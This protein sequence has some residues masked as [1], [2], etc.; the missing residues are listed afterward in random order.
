MSI[1][2]WPNE[3][4]FNVMCLAEEAIE[5]EKPPSPKRGRSRQGGSH[6]DDGPAELVELMGVREVAR[7]SR[8]EHRQNHAGK[9]SYP[10]RYYLFE[11]VRAA[12]L[13]PYP[14]TI[15]RV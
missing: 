13:T 2:A 15:Q 8:S 11:K 7:Q 3:I 12:S 6:H 4:S 5:Q 9:G 14:L 1:R 10:E